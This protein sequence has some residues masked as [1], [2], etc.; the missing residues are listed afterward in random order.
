MVKKAADANKRS[1]VAEVNFALW[2]YYM[3]R[4]VLV[5]LEKHD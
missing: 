3:Q 2:Q 1:K 4:G 5:N